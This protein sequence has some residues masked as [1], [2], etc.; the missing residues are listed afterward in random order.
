MTAREGAATGC[1]SDETKSLLLVDDDQPFLFSLLRRIRMMHGGFNVYTA[2]NGMQARAIL[3]TIPIDLVISDLN[4]PVMDGMEL[5]L[6]LAEARPRVPAIMMSDRAE[7]ET[8]AAL[9]QKGFHFLPK[10]LDIQELVRT[11]QPL[12]FGPDGANSGMSSRHLAGQED[13]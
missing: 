8:I 4:M 7:P 11:L 3:S 6:W 10:P 13:A 2:A 1:D 9:A 5:A 12:V